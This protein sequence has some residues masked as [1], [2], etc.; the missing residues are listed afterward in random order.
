MLK[1]LHSQRLFWLATHLLIF[2]TA[3][4]LF[5]Y[6]RSCNLQFTMIVYIHLGNLLQNLFGEHFFRGNQEFAPL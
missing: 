4:D 1:Q 3:G 6:L 2:I 5:Y